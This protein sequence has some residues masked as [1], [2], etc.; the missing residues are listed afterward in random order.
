MS[1]S[2]GSASVPRTALDFG[3]GYSFGFLGSL[4]EL[5]AVARVSKWWAAII[6]RS[7]DVVFVVT[8]VAAGW[9]GV[10]R[11]RERGSWLGS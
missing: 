3:L 1:Q 6:G 4:Q 8:A 10:K 5:M 7:L 9:R 2:K 11:R